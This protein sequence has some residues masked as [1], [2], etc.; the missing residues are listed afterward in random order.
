[1]KELSN[2]HCEEC[3]GTGERNNGY[4][5]YPCNCIRQKQSKITEVEIGGYEF[6]PKI[7]EGLLVTKDQVINYLR[8]LKK[9]ELDTLLLELDKRLTE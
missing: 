7:V 9:E 6:K 8:S 5:N 4:F 1:M 2:P 3:G